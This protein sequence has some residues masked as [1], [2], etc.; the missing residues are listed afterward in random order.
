VDE[1]GGGGGALHDSDH[2]SLLSP[3]LAEGG[4][5]RGRGREWRERE[6]ASI[7]ATRFS[8]WASA[9]VDRSLAAWTP[10]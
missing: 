1:Q 7:E 8:P 6:R 10:R 9:C 4:E 2:F 3:F 5:W